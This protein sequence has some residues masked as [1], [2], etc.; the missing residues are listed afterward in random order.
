MFE[1]QHC[2]TR[3]RLDICT[4]KS[5]RVI[6]LIVVLINDRVREL[7]CSGLTPK[8]EKKEVQIYNSVNCF[9]TIVSQAI[10]FMCMVE[11]NWVSA[12]FS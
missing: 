9:E 6:V 12:V 2:K 5:D 4:S 8:W 3:Y 11:K 7:P 10:V 1:L